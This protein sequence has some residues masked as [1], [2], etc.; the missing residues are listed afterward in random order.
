MNPISP[1]RLTA[2]ERLAELG[3]ILVA[4][5]RRL[6]ARQSSRLSGERE[7]SFVDFTANQ[8][9]HAAE[10]EPAENNA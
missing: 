8:S 4:G 9:G 1:D 6:Q 5:V 10:L 2:A 7:N 3:T